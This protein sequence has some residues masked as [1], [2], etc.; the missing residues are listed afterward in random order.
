M[1]TK[2]RLSI[3]P[4]P[5]MDEVANEKTTTAMA[6]PFCTLRD[7]IKNNSSDFSKNLVV[8][9]IVT[10]NPIRTKTSISR[11][12]ENTEANSCSWNFCFT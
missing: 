5:S 6:I 7:I 11:E 3:V 9:G 8:N 4:I 12:F 10:I 1:N 2:E